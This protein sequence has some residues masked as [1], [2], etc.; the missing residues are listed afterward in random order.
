M[1]TQFEISR[2]NAAAAEAKAKEEAEAKKPTFKRYQ[3]GSVYRR[4]NLK[5]EKAEDDEN[6]LPENL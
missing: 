1:S 3:G 4:S 2:A 5:S 6:D